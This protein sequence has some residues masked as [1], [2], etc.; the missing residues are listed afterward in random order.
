MEQLDERVEHHDPV[1]RAVVDSPLINEV[2]RKMYCLIVNK[3]D[4][5]TVPEG[6][7]MIFGEMFSAMYEVMGKIGAVAPNFSNS[8][9]R[10]NFINNLTEVISGYNV[11][12]HRKGEPGLSSAFYVFEQ[13][14]CDYQDD[15]VREKTL[16]NEYVY[17]ALEALISQLFYYFVGSVNLKKSAVDLNYL[18]VSEER[19]LAD[20][21]LV[22]WKRNK[23]KLL[24]RIDQ[25][26][27]RS[28][29]AGCCYYDLPDDELVNYVVLETKQG[30]PLEKIF[31]EILR[32][33]SLLGSFK[34]HLGVFN[35]QE[36]DHNRHLFR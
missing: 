32:I 21:L 3:P 12:V 7:K 19:M 27:V 28:C 36:L 13:Q 16:R 34:T 24:L 8:D 4:E 23:G 6:F 9:W 18:D 29:K 33:R 26:G 31:A 20:D 1:F 25:Y 11:L 5:K 2:V 17:E 10:N 35:Y 14:L 30:D 15:H 22:M